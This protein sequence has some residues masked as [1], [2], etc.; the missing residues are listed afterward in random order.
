MSV[1]S[2]PIRFAHLA[3]LEFLCIFGNLHFPTASSWLNYLLRVTFILCVVMNIWLLCHFLR[4]LKAT[5][6]FFFYYVVFVFLTLLLTCKCFISY[7]S[8]INHLINCE[9]ALDNY[10]LLCC[11]P[12]LVFHSSSILPLYCRRFFFAFSLRFVPPFFLTLKYIEVKKWERLLYMNEGFLTFMPLPVKCYLISLLLQSLD[13]T[14]FWF[15]F[16]SFPPLIL[17][18]RLSVKLFS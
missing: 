7:C 14:L 10:I 1:Q 4:C 9:L 12:S 3:L 6:L 13:W 17:A 5:N 18:L 8:T 2:R 16:T 15:P 11:L